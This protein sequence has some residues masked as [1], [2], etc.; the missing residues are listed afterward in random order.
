MIEE[1]EI[2]YHEDPVWREHANFMIHARLPEEDRPKRFEQLWT[3]RLADNRFEICCIPFLVFGLALGDVVV[4]S[5]R[6]DFQYVVDKVIARS[7]RYVFRV[8]FSPSFHPRDE[9][10]AGLEALGSLIEWPSRNMLV[11]DA[12]DGEHTRAV[13]DFLM[14]HEMEG[15]LAYQAATS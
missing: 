9:I 1:E 3:R 10:A 5:P 14:K 4:T 6:E 15:H 11:V 8:Q 7:G 13:V 2:A 12:A